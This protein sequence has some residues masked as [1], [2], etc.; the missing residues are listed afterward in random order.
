MCGSSTS[1]GGS[2]GGS[3]GSGGSSLSAQNLGVPGG[4]QPFEINS[5]GNKYENGVKYNSS[6]TINA[7][8]YSPSEVQNLAKE[9][10]SKGETPMM[11]RSVTLN[12]DTGK[13]E[14]SN[15][16]KAQSF[17][18][19]EIKTYGVTSRGANDYLIFSKK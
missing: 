6:E 5:T 3:G 7:K 4:N 11:A 12:K 2:S 1:S 16:G 14:M 15:G 10:Q 19:S 9:I 8:Y 13:V 18:P 17:S